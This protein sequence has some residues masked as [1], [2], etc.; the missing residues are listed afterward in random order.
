[1]TAARAIGI[2]AVPFLVGSCATLFDGT[3]QQ[4]SVDTAPAGARCTF[5]RN[6]DAIASIGSTPGSATIKKTK[7]D[8]TIVCSKP[9]YAAATYLNRSG[10]AGVTWANVMTVGLAWVVDSASGADN[11]YDS[12]VSLALAPLAD[13]PPAPMPAAQPDA[14]PSPPPTAPPPPQTV[15]PAAMPMARQIECAA[16]DGSR[17]RVTGGACP[18]G[19]TLAR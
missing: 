12:P 3:M 1:M 18:A 15:A 19:W 14:P 4:I 16:T 5:W 2:L 8:L 9:G 17:L 7:S 13:G 11:K 10:L 6:G